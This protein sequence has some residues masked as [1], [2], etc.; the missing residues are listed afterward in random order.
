MGQY[1]WV[2][3]RENRAVETVSGNWSHGPS[4]D[5]LQFEPGQ[6]WSVHYINNLEDSN[7]IL[8]LRWLA[9]A[10]RNLPIMFTRIH[11]PDDPIWKEWGR[12]RSA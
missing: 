8:V 10:S 2:T 1:Q 5:V 11:P 7:L 6:S 12:N 4:E 9:L 3:T